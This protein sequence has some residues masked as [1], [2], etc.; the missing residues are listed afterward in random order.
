[1]K[2]TSCT[3]F[4]YK[5]QKSLIKSD[6]QNGLFFGEFGVNHSNDFSDIR[7]NPSLPSQQQQS[8]LSLYNG[9]NDQQLYQWQIEQKYKLMGKTSYKR[10]KYWGEP[11]D[12]SSSKQIE[13]DNF[14]YK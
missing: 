4:R 10:L 3:D 11:V 1:M 13:L 14:K 5:G 8:E 6:D 7:N 12:C 2:N 9:A